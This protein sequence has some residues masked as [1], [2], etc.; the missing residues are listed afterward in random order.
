MYC[1]QLS[2]GVKDSSCVSWLC[3]RLLFFL[4]LRGFSKGL[5]ALWLQSY[6]S[7]RIE[8]CGGCDNGCNYT[9]ADW[10]L[11]FIQLLLLKA[12][13]WA[14]YKLVIFQDFVLDFHST[15]DD[16]V[17]RVGIMV[18]AGKRIW[19]NVVVEHSLRERY[20]TVLWTSE[21]ISIRIQV[22]LRR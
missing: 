16:V 12:C 1:V 18:F 4:R 5:F 3:L 7:V 22:R 11:F 13:M 17:Y 15:R 21:D 14:I 2:H 8:T 6:C 9:A 10:N 19:F 20:E